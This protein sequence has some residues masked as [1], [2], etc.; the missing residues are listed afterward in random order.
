[1]VSLGEQE[2]TLLIV[3]DD[4]I[5]TMSIKRALRKHKIGNPVMTASDG[6]EALNLMRTVLKTK[7]FVVL[8]DLNMP[9]MNG[10]E[11]LDAVRQDPHLKQTVIF[12]LTTS[13]S[14]YDID[15]CYKRQVAGY[16]TKDR[17]GKDFI[18]L[19]TVL[20]GYWRIAYLPQNLDFDDESGS[21]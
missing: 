11:F 12:V 6:I 10:I 14:R 9:R 1:M 20:D 18:D 16:F 4:E 19:I 7:N 8:L 15:E 21:Q 17:A 3:D 13:A 2:I 5:D